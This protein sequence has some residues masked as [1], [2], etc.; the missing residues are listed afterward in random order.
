M[1]SISTKAINSSASVGGKPAAPVLFWASV[2][3]VMCVVIAYT[4]FQW[5]VSDHF[6][7][8]PVGTD[9]IPDG[10]LYFVRAI[11]V[12]ATSCGLALIW[13]TLIN[14]WR[15]TGEVSWDGMLCVVALSLWF[16]D[17]IDN[18]FNFV[19]S[20]NAYFINFTSWAT[21]IPGWES[22][23]QE[24]FP[25]PLFLMG[26]LYI[27]FLCGLV[28]LGCWILNK[29]KTT[30]LPNSSVLMHLLVCFAA[31][32]VFDLIVEATL[33]R[34]EIFAYGGSYHALTLWAGEYYQFPLY[35]SFCVAGI[36]TTLTVLRYFKDDKGYSFAERGVQNLNL[37]KSG[38]KMVSF[39]SIL[40]FAHVAMFVVFFFPFN[41]F[42]LK[43][44]SYPQTSS[45]L[46][47]EVCGKGT[48]YACPSREVP[49]P[50]KKSLAIGP[51]D[52]RLSAGAKA[53]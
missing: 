48:P 23:R 33:C 39:L 17:P 13:Y 49:I 42:S 12:F 45:Y 32:F 27:V 37:P 4:L 52:P 16:Q 41:W 3:V 5:F 21:Y 40:G 43:A 15:K 2:G 30:W 36:G 51:D 53:N 8:A 25:E 6:R 46:R 11:E 19:F 29:C 20:Y 47:Y 10:V 26:G 28:I 22:P 1:A 31:F 35:E 38:K 7:P 44:D 9:I 24:N 18:Y 14:P 50:S 34:Y